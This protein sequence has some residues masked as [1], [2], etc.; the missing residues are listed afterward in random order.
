MWIGKYII[1]YF[2]FYCVDGKQDTVPTT[3]FQTT[4]AR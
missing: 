4:I 1:D 2:I 3:L